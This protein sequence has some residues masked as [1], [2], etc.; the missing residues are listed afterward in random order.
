VKELLRLRNARAACRRDDLL[1]EEALVDIRDRGIETCLVRH[2]GIHNILRASGSRMLPQHWVGD[3]KNPVWISLCRIP[4]TNNSVHGR[5]R[6]LAQRGL[7]SSELN[8]NTR[9]LRTSAVVPPRAE[10]L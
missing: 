2:D 7:C 4:L 9:D 5:I 1:A 6:A 3:N 10:P 8:A